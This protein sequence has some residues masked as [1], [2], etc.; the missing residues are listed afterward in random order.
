LLRADSK[1]MRTV[2]RTEFAEARDQIAEIRDQILST[3][4]GLR[5]EIIAARGE[6]RGDFRTLIGVVMA[7]WTAAVLAVVGLLLQHL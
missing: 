7:M 1:E 6:S 5:G 2:M 4:R 3:E